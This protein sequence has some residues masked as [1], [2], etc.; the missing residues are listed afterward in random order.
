MTVLF[1]PIFQIPDGAV[2]AYEALG[3]GRHS[4]LPESPAELLCIAESIGAEAALSPLFRRKAVELVRHRT[5][6]PT[7]FLNMHPAE[8]S[9]PGFELSRVRGSS[10]LC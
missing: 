9:Q 5:N 4:R 6:L 8:L 10:S 3:R 1:Q 2:R 7:L